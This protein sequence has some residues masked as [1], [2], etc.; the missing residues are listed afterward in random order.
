VKKITFAALLTFATA[1]TFLLFN[2]PAKADIPYCHVYDDSAADHPG[3]YVDGYREGVQSA[4]NGDRYQRRSAGGD[5]AIGF[6]D[7]FFHRR[8]NRSL[9]HCDSSVDD[10]RQRYINYRGY[11]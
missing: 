9:A 1:P 4:R 5:F 11:R 2:P 3:A 8:F 6:R 7:G 10:N